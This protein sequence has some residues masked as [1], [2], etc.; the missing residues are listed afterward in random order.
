M[1]KTTKSANLLFDG[2]N[3]DLPVRSP[4]IGPKVID[5]GKLYNEAVYS[6]LIQV[7]PPLPLVKAQ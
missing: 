5:I 1:E 3:Y 7:S 6:L 2:K 4:S